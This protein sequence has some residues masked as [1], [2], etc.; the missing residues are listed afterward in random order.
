MRL[1]KAWWPEFLIGAACVFFAFRELGT[2]P[3]PWADDSLF[4]IVARNLAEGRGYQFPIFDHPWYYS[5]FLAIGP[6][7]VVPAAIGIKLFG[8]SVAAARLGTLPYIFLATFLLYRYAESLGGKWNA[9]FAAL[10]LVTFSAFINTGKPVMGEVPGFC[11]ML[12]GFLACRGTLTAK[13]SVLSGMAFGL[14]VVTKITAGVVYPA[15]GLAWLAALVRKD[16]RDLRLLTLLGAVSFITLLPFLHVLGYSDP[17]FVQE[18][19]QYGF[20]GGGSQFLQVLRTQPELLTRF[21]YLAYGIF[22]VSG[23]LGMYAL[24]EKLARREMVMALSLFFLVTL[25][26]L[27]ERGWYRHL[28]LSHFLLLAFVPAGFRMIFTKRTATFMLAGIVVAQTWWQWDHRGSRRTTEAADSAAILAQSYTETELLF[29]RPEVYV[30][31]PYNPHWQYLSDEF[32]ARTY[33]AFADLPILQEQHCMAIVQKIGLEQQAQYGSR[34]T[35][36]SGR[37]FIVAPPA[38]CAKSS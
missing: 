22:L 5:F 10:L 13:K 27:D 28:L 11:F 12:L 14:A 1:L 34:L 29:V 31:L 18:L 16:M 6:T 36:L 17:V 23:C 25:Y 37:Y 3:E 26:F 8:F 9:R 15:I 38:E 30:Q 7:V 35:P 4:M 24:R 32:Q 33:S 21:Q 2:F 19:T 20:A